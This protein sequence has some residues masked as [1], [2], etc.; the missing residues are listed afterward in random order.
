MFL[1]TKISFIR[2]GESPCKNLHVSIARI[3][4]VLWCVVTELSFSSNFWKD[5]DLSLYVILNA[6]SYIW[7]IL[8]LRLRLWNIQTNGQDPNYDFVK[9]FIIIVFNQCSWKVQDKQERVLSSWHV[10][11]QRL[12]T[13]SW[14][15]KSLSI[16][17]P[18]SI[19]FVFDSMEGPSIS[20]VEVHCNLKECDLCHY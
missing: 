18:R 1:S 15:F 20:A 3:L 10:F 12:L 9:A 11:L 19:S 17:I 2:G 4:I 7:F 5:D 6:L 13:S 14:N 8:L 16:V